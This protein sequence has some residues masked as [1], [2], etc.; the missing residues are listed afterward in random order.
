MRQ[1]GN[2]EQHNDKKTFRQYKLL[3][4]CEQFGLMNV[5]V[6]TCLDVFVRTYEGQNVRPHELKAF[7][8][9]KM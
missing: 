2:D 6:Y 4:E 7:L 8:R 1:V 9:L 5:C 3:E